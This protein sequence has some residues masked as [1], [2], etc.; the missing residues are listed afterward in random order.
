MAANLKLDKETLIKHRFW[1]LS[2]LVLLLWL[3]AFIPIFGIRST[4]ADNAK[5]A[6]T[7]KNELQA[8][9]TD[10][11][12]RGPKDLEA[13]DQKRLA[14][15]KKRDILTF[16]VQA[17]QNDVRRIVDETVLA[18]LRQVD[19]VLKLNLAAPPKKP[20]PMPMPTAETETPTPMPE[21]EAPP[22]PGPPREFKDEQRAF[23]PHTVEKINELIAGIK[24]RHNVDVGI[25]AFREIPQDKKEAWKALTTQE[26]R[27]KFFHDWAK[28][29]HDAAGFDGI[30][31]FYCEDPIYFKADVGAE[32]KKKAF[33]E[34]DRAKL[35]DALWAGLK[36]P[37]GET[38]NRD[39]LVEVRNPLITWPDWLPANAL[40]RLRV[41]DFGEPIK[42]ELSTE[43]LRDYLKQFEALYD[44]VNPPGG[45]KLVDF[46][47]SG[48][49]EEQIRA[50]LK[51]YIFPANHVV[52]TEEG[53]TIQEQLAIQR[54]LLRIVREVNDIQAVLRPEWREV[55]IPEPPKVEKPKED[56]NNPGGTPVP[57]TAAPM[58]PAAPGTPMTPAA[59]DPTATTGT[60]EKKEPP[61][62][63][64][65]I[66]RKRFLNTTWTYGPKEIEEGKRGS[67]WWENGWMLDLELVPQGDE[68]VLQG[69]VFNLSTER[70]IPAAKVRLILSD[71]DETNPAETFLD[72]DAG[73]LKPNPKDLKKY[74]LDSIS[75]RKLFKDPVKV[76]KGVKRLVRI[77]PVP[78]DPVF[79]HQRFANPHWL[80]DVQLV[81]GTGAQRQL[82][83]TVYNRSSRYILPVNFEI[84]ARDERGDRHK[85]DIKIGGDAF[86]AGEHRTFQQVSAGQAPVRVVEARQVLT[87]KTVPVKAI[88]QLEVGTPLALADRMSNQILLPYNFARKDPSKKPGEEATG[89]GT[90]PQAPP[91]GAAPQQGPGGAAAG[92]GGGA[93]G[94]GSERE[95]NWL[96]RYVPEK[97]KE[98]ESTTPPKFGGNDQV[99]RVPVA[100]K[101]IIDQAYKADVEAAVV[102]SRLRILLQQTAWQRFAPRQAAA[103]GATAAKADEDTS[104]IE[105]HIFGLA[106]IYEDPEAWARIQKAK[107]TAGQGTGSGS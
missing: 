91:G 42:D 94:F 4:I 73:G 17:S 27:A 36:K 49:K 39:E 19:A 24:L 64:A 30:H 70:E 33:P 44:I 22:P 20:A 68:V 85:T 58:P 69:T 54:E 96:R 46:P 59:P 10:P 53:W 15:E 16:G 14:A 50:L 100:M 55:A 92:A 82:K 23:A 97:G 99:R 86:K 6:E 43:Y 25:D 5:S 56:P 77:Q 66:D 98:S 90:G 102:N 71:G 105:V 1:F 3:I 75:Q 81:R 8:V 21:A 37:S 34:K 18:G 83:G 13:A 48:S 29:R 63:P 87:E 32:T 84:Y 107:E 89:G 80:V 78:V 76:A 65:P 51:P 7:T 79:D 12:I 47:V 57:P 41:R 45:K 93:G 31:I 95:G 62:P 88:Y 61:P 40:G 9:I 106:T 103:V 2:G 35:T 67:R 101:L 38:R 72:L 52:T 11:G 60:E 26:A 104:E 28:E 74:K